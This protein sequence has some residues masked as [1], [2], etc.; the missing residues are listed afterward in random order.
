MSMMHDRASGGMAHHGENAYRNNT[1]HASGLCSVEHGVAVCARPQASE[2]RHRERDGR[3][4]P[5]H[6]SVQVRVYRYVLYILYGQYQPF[7]TAC[8]RD[9]AM[10]E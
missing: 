1:Q 3:R 4:A 6:T 8:A 2:P 7:I 9:A 10:G 5:A